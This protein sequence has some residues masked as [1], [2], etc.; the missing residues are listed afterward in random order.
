MSYAEW[1]PSWNANVA[2]VTFD[3]KISDKIVCLWMGFY[4][5]R[6]AS[7]AVNISIGVFFTV[8][9]QIPKRTDRD[10]KC[11]YVCRV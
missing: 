8:D 2:I 9:D 1:Q 7:T 6:P 10:K 3:T 11:V 5:R 4:S